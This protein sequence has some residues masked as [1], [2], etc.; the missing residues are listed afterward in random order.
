MDSKKMDIGF[1]PQSPESAPECVTGGAEHSRPRGT[2]SP[3]L[4]PLH[5]QHAVWLRGTSFPSPGLSFHPELQTPGVQDKKTPGFQE[6]SLFLMCLVLKKGGD[7]SETT[8]STGS[9]APAPSGAGSKQPVQA[10]QCSRLNKESTSAHS[11]RKGHSRE[12]HMHRKHGQ[13]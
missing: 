11:S 6:Q 1:Q 13:R 2:Q 9:R 7:G 4:P 5:P 12:L 8:C 3:V 10:R